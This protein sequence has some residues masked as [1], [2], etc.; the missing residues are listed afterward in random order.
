MRNLYLLLFL[1]IAFVQQ[2]KTQLAN[3]TVSPNFNVQDLN[4]DFHN[5]YADYLD[6]G[7]DVV[8]DFSATWCGPCWN[9]H[10]TNTLKNF[11]NSY[12]P[13]GTGE[14]TVI[15]LEA[16]AS[17]NVQCL[18]GPTGCVGGTQGNW[19]AGTPYPIAHL[20]GSNG[21]LST[22]NANFNI[23]FFPT[24]YMISAA[25]KKVYSQGTPS[26]TTLQNW[27]FGS[28]RM[29]ATATTTNAFCGNNG[30]ITLDVTAGY[31]NK[32]YQW[33]NGA[34]T[35][36]L[37][38]LVPGTY[39]CTITDANNYSIVTDEFDVDGIT[40]LMDV[41]L[42]SSQLPSCFGSTNGSVTVQA[43]SIYG[44]YNYTWDNGATGATKF[45]AS[46][47]N[48]SVT[49]TDAQGCVASTVVTLS[50]PDPIYGDVEAPQ[51]P[52]SQNTGYAAI[53]ADGGTSPYSYQLNNGQ[54]TSNYFFNNINPGNYTYKIIDN[55]GCQFNGAFQLSQQPGPTAVINNNSNS[56]TLT[57]ITTSIQ[58]TASGG[59]TYAWSGGSTPGTAANTFTA[60]GNYVVTVTSNNGCSDTETINIIANNT[61]PQAVITNNDNSTVITCVNSQV[62]VTAS[63]GNTYNWSGGT[64][65]NTPVNAFTQP[66]SYAL[67]VTAAN[68]CTDTENIT[69]TQNTT[70]PAAV[71]Q[72]TSNITCVVSEAQL[73]GTGSAA[74]PGI[75][76]LWSTTD[77]NIVSGAESL[78]AV[79]NAGGTYTLKVTNGENG[80]TAQSSTAVVPD[81]EVPAMDVSS[82]GNE[83]TCALPSVALCADVEDGTTVVW[84]IGG[85]MVE[86][87]CASV[88][89]AGSYQA[90]ATGSNGCV[91]TESLTI[92][93]DKTVP[94]LS[95]TGGELTCSDNEVEI[96]GET[97]AGA[98]IIWNIQGENIEGNC[99]TV[100]SAGSYEATA[101]G[102]NGCTTT[103]EA[104]VTESDDLPQA[105]IADPD[106]LTCNVN[107]VVL[108]GSVIGN[109]DD[110]TYSWSTSNGN[111]VSGSNTSQATVDEEGNYSLEV[112]NKANGCK[113]TKSV[114]VAYEFEEMLLSNAN[115]VNDINNQN[116]GS[117]ALSING[118]T[119]ALS[120]LWSNGQTTSSITGLGAGQYS[121]TVTDAN[122]CEKV[123]GPFVIENVSSSDE[124]AFLSTFQVYPNPASNMVHIQADFLKKGDVLVSIISSMGAQ[125]S[126]FTTQGSISMNL[127]I[128]NLPSGIYTIFVT[129]NNQKAGRR[130]LVNR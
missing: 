21:P 102:A 8:L 11:Y 113:T 97:G 44:G 73:S 20:D 47:G 76:Y 24:V 26:Q 33:N 18:Y 86:G 124:T 46:A 7:I 78:N 39:K 106:K 107:Q 32:T 105:Q 42:A 50:Q 31:G 82:N 87:T 48:H 9:Y 23:N 92:G 109:P 35:K 17:T 2:G 79:V 117:I 16:S 100:N 123:F 111:I 60:A 54:P 74:G 69:I 72:A 119:G 41:E 84:N 51:I 85:E 1:L 15:Y 120:Y 128:S 10:N 43:S 89:N 68:G 99:A 64:S 57:C 101:T 127:D 77:G 110:F 93:E 37:T 112:T 4:G 13:P 67:T 55:N 3:G 25:N 103:M 96:C 6:Q 14:V 94:V 104:Q 88:E 36:N 129:Q 59:N 95:V 12:G 45:N 108:E 126:Q 30:T 70:Q 81:T 71:S 66:G 125:V 19:V 115:V 53:V 29:A 40:D 118:G 121:C 38:G 91:S 62:D 114:T 49:V 56:N 61:P 122:G 27:I 58:V 116:N 75:T 130:M 98:S 28:F 52:C 80:C 65:Q 83:V 63:G 5:L 22:V 90:T 34:T